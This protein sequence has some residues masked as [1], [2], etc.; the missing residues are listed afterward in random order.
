V[1]KSIFTQTREKL[2]WLIH[3]RKLPGN[4]LPSEEELA[5]RLKVS[6]G[7]VREVLSS[8][9]R[10]GIISKKHGFGNF[11][12]KSALEARMRIDQLEE[13]YDLIEDGGYE[14]TIHIEDDSN[15][16]LIPGEKIRTQLDLGEDK[17]AYYLSCVYSADQAAAIYCQMYFPTRIFL[18]WPSS[19]VQGKS[20]FQLL[21]N[22]CN[23][24]VDHTLVWFRADYCDEE[25][26]E[27]LNVPVASPIMVWEELLYNFFDEI[28]CT[29][30]SYFNPEIMQVCMLRKRGSSI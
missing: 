23:Q 10:E 19:D 24:E 13:F 30:V 14:P 22:C 1:G 17:Q 9:N 7:T 2:L 6:R 28:I 4:K 25:V 29:S 21:K 27:K 11:I 20:I 26:A 15:R 16:L 5:E 8:L 3:N 18:E 12:Q